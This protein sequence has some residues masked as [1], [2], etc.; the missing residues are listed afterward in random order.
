MKAPGKLTLAKE[1]SPSGAIGAKPRFTVA[2]LMKR[3]PDGNIPEMP[4]RAERRVRQKARDLLA[5]RKAS[6]TT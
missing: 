4:G 1:A 2:E 5:A 3:Y 6:T